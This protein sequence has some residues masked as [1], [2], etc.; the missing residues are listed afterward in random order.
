MLFLDP[1]NTSTYIF[2]AGN[3]TQI[4]TLYQPST[5]RCLAGGYP[6]PSVTWWKGQIMLPFENEQYHLGIDY[7]MTLS[8]VLLSDLG[9]YTCQAYTT[10]G[11]PSVSTIVLKAYGP[12][13]TTYPS[14]R[15]YLK[16]II[17][18]PEVTARPQPDSRYPYRPVRPSPG[19][20]AKPILNDNLSKYYIWVSSYQVMCATKHSFLNKYKIVFKIIQLCLFLFNN[21]CLHIVP[22]TTN[23]VLSNGNNFAVGSVLL[24][25]CDVRGSPK[26]TVTWFKDNTQLDSND[27]IQIT[28][29]FCYSYVMFTCTFI[30]FTLCRIQSADYT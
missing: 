19:V 21:T 15:D 12:I 7:S 17:T 27:R 20:V 29:M 30:L 16:Y 2:A 4:A 9:E 5:L 1:V 23:I 11:K 8:R 10:S 28:G 6:K 22:V 25:Q 24:L 18:L 3:I 13:H 26:P 14:D